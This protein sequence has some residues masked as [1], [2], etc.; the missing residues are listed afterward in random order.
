[1]PVALA[2]LCLQVHPAAAEPEAKPEL[3]AKPEAE[4]EA[5]VFPSPEALRPAIAFWKR[6]YLEVTTSGGLI[7]DSRHLGVVYEVVR[8]DST[9]PR[10]RETEVKRRKR[11][12]R[13]ALRHLASGKAPSEDRQHR[14]ARALE[15]ALGHAPSTR[16]YARASRRIRFQLGQR[17]EFRA[18]LIRSGAFDAAMRAVLLEEGMP[19]GLIALPY[20]ESSFN[21]SA[22]SK[23]GA[24]GPWQFMRSTGRRFLKIDYVVDERLDPLVA[25]RAAARLL[26]KNYESLASWPLAITAYNHGRAGMARAVRRLGTRDIERIIEEYRSRSFGFASRNFYVQF[27]AASEILQI[28]ESY[29]GPLMRDE[30][31]LVDEVTLPYYTELAD[32]QDLGVSL[33][34][35]KQ[36]NP[37]LRPPVFRGLKRIPRNFKLKLP[38]GSV[39]EDPDAWLARVPESGRYSS[40]TRSRYYRVR[41]GDTLGKIARRNRT[42]VSALVSQNSLRN[43]HRIRKGQVLELPS[44]GRNARPGSPKAPKASP[45]AAETRDAERGL[46]PGSPPTRQT[47]EARPEPEFLG[48]WLALEPISDDVHWHRLLGNSTAVGPLETLG[49]FADWLGVATQ[50]LRQLNHLKGRDLLKLGQ[51]I[52]LDFSRTPEQVFRQRRLQYHKGIEEDFFESFV[53]T[54]TIEHRL[55]IGDNLWD[56][57]RETYSVPIWLIQRYN[58]EIDLSQLVPG[59]K[60]SVPVIEPAGRAS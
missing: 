48:P 34:L 46:W 38:A 4:L 35:V 33:E 18:G 5:D 55:Q 40:Q 10:R 12:W 43:R 23:Y 27:L 6:V 25:T 14:A 49:H 19:E 58:P 16:E 47:A 36:L 21:L 44:P 45:P 24:A 30:P 13:D 51:R 9:N 53:I 11:R 57:S 54:G 2:L 41:G 32:L 29:F 39:G 42:T 26:R 20:V 50:R 59:R 22:Y 60:L 52:E 37:S 3:E 56:L 15:A 31:R 1:M 8:L 7:H 28:H 17:D